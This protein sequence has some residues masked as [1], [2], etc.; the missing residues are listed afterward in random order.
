MGPSPPGR[1]PGL[2]DRWPFRPS[3]LPNVLTRV[4][5]P[6]HAALPPSPTRQ[7]PY[8]AEGPY[9]SR[10][11]LHEPQAPYPTRSVLTRP[12]ALTRAAGSLP[13]AQRPYT[14]EALYTAEGP[15]TSRRLLARRVSVY[16]LSSTEYTEL[17]LTNSG[18]ISFIFFTVAISSYC[19]LMA[20]SSSMALLTSP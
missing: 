20:I 1:C 6:L 2:G 15:Y 5:G 3:K 12:K 7:R 19:R 4:A 14:R 18:T 17:L 13:D 10:R 9:T 8:T 11:P 16:F